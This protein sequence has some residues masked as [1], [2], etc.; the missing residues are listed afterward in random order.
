VCTVRAAICPKGSE[1]SSVRF[2]YAAPPVAFDASPD[3][4]QARLAMPAALRAA[5]RATKVGGGDEQG[6]KEE[7]EVEGAHVMGLKGAFTPEEGLRERFDIF[8][9][10][11]R[12]CKL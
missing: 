4:W 1:G 12:S 8:N 11:Y 2:E 7:Q 9:Y 6:R 5:L 10:L 3:S